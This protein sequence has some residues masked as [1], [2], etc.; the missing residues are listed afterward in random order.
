MSEF[1]NFQPNDIVTYTGVLGNEIHPEVYVVVKQKKGFAGMGY[2]LRNS[3]GVVD[4]Y[5][6]DNF[7]LANSVKEDLGDDFPIENHI[8]PNCKVE[9]V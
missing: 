6:G 2:L 8:S 3:H 7:V 1:K 5:Y 9:D 4:F